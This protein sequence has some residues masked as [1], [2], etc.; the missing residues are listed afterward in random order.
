[1]PG[2][3]LRQGEKAFVVQLV[4]STTDEAKKIDKTKEHATTTPED[5]MVFILPFF[6]FSCLRCKKW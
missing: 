3:H 2:S 6:F 4:A 5:G 1:M